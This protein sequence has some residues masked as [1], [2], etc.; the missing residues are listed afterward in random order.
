LLLPFLALAS[1][2][3]STQSR[4]ERALLADKTPAA[5]AQDLQ[6]YYRLHCPDVL[7][8]QIDGH[9]NQSGLRPIGANGQIQVD[10]STAVRAAGETTPAVALALAHDLRLSDQAVHVRV[11][12]H[13]S[14]SLYVF[15][16]VNSAQK[17]VPYVGP[18][19]VLDLLQRVGG[20]PPGAVL[21]DVQI[22]RPHVADGK[23]PEVFHVNLPAILRKHDQQTNIHL[24]PFD[25]IYLA[26][27]RRSRL[28]C[29]VPPL[30]Q[31]LY[32]KVCGLQE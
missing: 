23:P 32:R 14:Q 22:V 4:L 8:L 15:S 5:H 20:T 24:E 7:E 12:E 13:R 21:G 31:P 30:L 27:G 2:C 9:P 19:T 3:I 26:Q 1:G 6:A 18:E 10:S 29:C 11:A 17:A 16:D 28:A 25:R